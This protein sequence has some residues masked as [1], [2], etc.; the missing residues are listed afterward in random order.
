VQTLPSGQSSGLVVTP[1]RGLRYNPHQ[2]SG[3]ANVTSPPYDVIGA[4]T[5]GELLQAD[6]HNVVR[7]ILP[8]STPHDGLAG[9]VPGTADPNEEA[10]RRLRSWRDAG[11]LVPDPEP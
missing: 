6:P 7:L 4:T 1:F 8:R 3:I 10:A 5:L 11:I 9:G 2:A